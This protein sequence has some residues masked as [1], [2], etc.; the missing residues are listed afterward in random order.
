MSIYTRKK[1]T[2]EEL[3]LN[4]FGLFIIRATC[5]DIVSD[6]NYAATV[7]FKIGYQMSGERKYGLIN[8]LTDG[9]FNPMANTL[10]E[11]CDLLNNDIDGYRLMT[12][13]EV[14]FLITYRKQGFLL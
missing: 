7:S 14:C 3:K 1:F 4:N 6:V 9:W 11:L 8:F 10:A 2:E 13:E 12:K 5:T